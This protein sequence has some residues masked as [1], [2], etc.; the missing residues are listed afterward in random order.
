MVALS[1]TY[2]VGYGRKIRRGDEVGE[3]QGASSAI[4]K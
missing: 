1:V 2:T 4:M 3:Q